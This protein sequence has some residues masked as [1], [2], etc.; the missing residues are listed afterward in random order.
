M[1]FLDTSAAIRRELAQQLVGLTQGYATRAAAVA[2][3]PVDAFFDSDETGSSR[4]YKRIAAAPGYV[5]VGATPE[6]TKASLGL[7]NVDN[8]SDAEKPVSTAQAAAI[9]EAFANTPI[10]VPMGDGT[11]DL[12]LRD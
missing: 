1:G 9:A 2:A 6:P 4:R 5:D 8:T 12:R 7:S 10:L 3:L 11:Y